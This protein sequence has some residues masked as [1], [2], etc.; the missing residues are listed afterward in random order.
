MS[1]RWSVD[2][3][4]YLTSNYGIVYASIDGRGTGFQS[5]EFM[6]KVFHALG[7]VEMADQISVTK[8]LLDTYQFLDASRTAIWG[9]SYGGYATAMTLIQDE[10]D[11][12]KCGLSVAPPTDWLLYDSMYTE[13]FM[14]LPTPLDNL[15]GYNKSSLL[16][17][18]SLP[19]SLHVM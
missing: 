4:D 1:Q 7:T 10:D 8:E 16:D 9:W 12:F 18:V 6:F 19:T 14:G 5:N 13:R 11:V 15:A 3:A 2:W 17:K